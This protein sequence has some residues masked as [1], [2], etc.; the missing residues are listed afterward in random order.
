MLSLVKKKCRYFPTFSRVPP[1]PPHRPPREEA[2]GGGGDPADRAHTWEEGDIPTAA[3]RVG[4]GRGSCS[5]PPPPGGDY[6]ENRPAE[7]SRRG[8][9][10]GRGR[11]RG[12]QVKQVCSAL[13]RA[14]IAQSVGQLAPSSDPRTPRFS[15]LDAD[16]RVPRLT[17]SGRPVGL[18]RPTLSSRPRCSPRPAWRPRA[19]APWSSSRAAW[20]PP[21]SSLSGSWS[22]RRRRRWPQPRKVRSGVVGIGGPGG[23]A[24]AV[25]VAV[26]GALDVDCG[27]GAA[28]SR[29]E[30]DGAGLPRP[31]EGGRWQE[32]AHTR[33][34]RE[35]PR[36][37]L[38]SPLWENG[39]GQ[40]RRVR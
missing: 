6:A 34:G 24:G 7:V 5:L 26:L 9:R 40:G 33:G 23:G 32:G 38:C 31:P 4:E 8:Q 19:L 39:L 37:G 29:L 11:G 36:L 10:P 25:V 15:P 28:V 21:R 16:P 18:R 30:M 20:R 12:R 35:Q 1:F 14:Q 27:E 3:S 2:P 17:P 22:P 13:P